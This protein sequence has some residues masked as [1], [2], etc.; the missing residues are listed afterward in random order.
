MTLN[1]DKAVL[2]KSEL[3]T[4]KQTLAIRCRR[5][6]RPAESRDRRLIGTGSFREVQFLRLTFSNSTERKYLFTLVDRAL[7]G[8]PVHPVPP[9]RSSSG[10]AVSLPFRYHPDCSGQVISDSSIDFFDVDSRSKALG[11]KLPSFECSLMLL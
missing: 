4:L 1:D 9:M 5:C 10:L 8:T 7:L 3:G 6:S 11:D 2:Q